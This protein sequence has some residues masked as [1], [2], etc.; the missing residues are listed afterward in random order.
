MQGRKNLPGMNYL[1]KG[2]DAMQGRKNLP[3][4]NY[5]G[6]GEDAMQGRKNLP[7]M[8]YLGKGEDAMK[9]RKILPGVNYLGKHVGLDNYCLPAEICVTCTKGIHRVRENL[10]KNLP[11]R[12]NGFKA[13]AIFIAW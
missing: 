12:H 6:K 4:M 7:G 11:T 10:L 9:G 5:L 13:R 2:E 3:G 1:G 8:N